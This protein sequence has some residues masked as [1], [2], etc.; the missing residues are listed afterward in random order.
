MFCPA[1][2]AIRMLY[3]CKIPQGIPIL[4]TITQVFGSVSSLCCPYSS[5]LDAE[6]H[7]EETISGALHWDCRD[8]SRVNSSSLR[9]VGTIGL[10]NSEHTK[11]QFRTHPYFRYC[12]VVS[13]WGAGSGCSRYPDLFF[14]RTAS[15]QI[16][17]YSAPSV[18]P[19]T[20]KFA[21]P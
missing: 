12:T 18:H 11:S 17:T 3:L 19:R 15:A 6:A 4:G 10:R 21:P 16:C 8:L 2:Q 14:Q 1:L 20:Y 9:R 7:T 5:L 13:S